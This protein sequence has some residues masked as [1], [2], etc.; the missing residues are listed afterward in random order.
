MNLRSLRSDGILL[1]TAMIWG[2]A[3]AAQ[4]AGMEY[5]GPFFYTGIRFA[6]GT[7]VL[8]PFWPRRRRYTASLSLSD[9][10]RRE[11]EAQARARTIRAGAVAGVVL[12]LGI[13]FQQ[14]G[15]VYTTAG[16]AGFI[17]GMYVVIVPII[18]ICIGRKTYL[19]GW[20]GAF[21]AIGG[22]YFLSMTENFTMSRGDVLIVVCAVFWAIHVLV[23]AKY[24][25]DVPFISLA[26]IQYAICAVLS[27]T[28]AVFA[29]PISISALTSASAPILYGGVVSVGI[30]YTLQIV[31]QRDAPPT[32][33]AIILSLE[34]VFAAVGGFLI[35]GEHLS[36]REVAGCALLLIGMIVSQLTRPRNSQ[37][38]A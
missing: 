19:G 28:I 4:R 8:F 15:I 22:L 27:L 12:T 30:A 14:V 17:T 18:A 13:L 9:R 23:L 10:S 6:L 16:K 1:L 37:N 7:L 20:I 11:V 24:A 34:G 29:E 33:A 3:F 31:G 2:T 36:L 5:I 26:V 25:P 32:H 35:L 21:L 38:R